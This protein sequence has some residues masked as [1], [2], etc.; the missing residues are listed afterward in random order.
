MSDGAGVLGGRVLVKV[1]PPRTVALEYDVFQGVEVKAVRAGFM[2]A[3][4]RDA[5]LLEAGEYELG[6]LEPEKAFQV[7]AL[8]P[9]FADGKLEEVEVEAGGTPYVDV[10]LSMGAPLA[11]MVLD[12]PGNTVDGAIV[13]VLPARQPPHR[14]PLMKLTP[15][16]HTTPPTTSLPQGR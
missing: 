10:P 1:L 14:H 13:A 15:T 5:W 2:D 3:T 11:G 12:A 8:S 4:L 7:L 16:T 9:R 6:G